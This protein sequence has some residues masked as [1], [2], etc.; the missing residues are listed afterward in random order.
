MDTSKIP[1]CEQCQ[2]ALIEGYAE[3]KT[4][5]TGERKQLCFACAVQQFRI[6]RSTENADKQKHTDH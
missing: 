5:L 4:A 1:Q 6:R 2:A 3:M